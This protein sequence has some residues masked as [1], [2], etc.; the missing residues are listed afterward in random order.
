MLSLVTPIDLQDK[1][2]KCDDVGE[3][4]K[5][6]LATQWHGNSS[7]L[8]NSPNISSLDPYQP[9]MAF[10][11]YVSTIQDQLSFCSNCK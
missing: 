4:Y 5:I 9:I 2:G 3:I 6:E 8:F 1:I 11:V 7:T 10:L